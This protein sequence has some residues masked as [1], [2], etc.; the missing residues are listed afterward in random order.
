MKKSWIRPWVSTETTF[1]VL[2][3]H[4]KSSLQEPMARKLDMF[5]LIC[6]GT[7]H[8]V[9]KSFIWLLFYSMLMIKGKKKP[10]SMLALTCS[11]ENIVL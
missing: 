3:I 4:P 10:H 11:V 9:L 2:N 7:A 5:I 6:P 1:L 8:E